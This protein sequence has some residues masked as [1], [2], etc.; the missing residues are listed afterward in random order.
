M[1]LKKIQILGA[2]VDMLRALIWHWQQYNEP[3]PFAEIGL[4]DTSLYRGSLKKLLDAKLVRKA[5]IKNFG[6]K[7]TRPGYEITDAGR[8]WYPQARAL[9][10][11]LI[12]QPTHK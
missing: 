10:D 1:T 11:G 3:V 12:K 2:Q 4:Y 7:G 5:K 8:T 9:Y 6:G